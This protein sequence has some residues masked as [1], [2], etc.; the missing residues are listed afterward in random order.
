MSSRTELNDF[1]DETSSEP[2]PGELTASRRAIVRGYGPP[3]SHTKALPR[4]LI[5][6]VFAVLRTQQPG[7][8]TLRTITECVRYFSI[9]FAYGACVEV[10]AASLTGRHCKS[11]LEGSALAAY[12]SVDECAHSIVAGASVGGTSGKPL[13]IR[14]QSLLMLHRPGRLGSP[15][16]LAYRR[17]NSSTSA[18]TLIMPRSWLNGSSSKETG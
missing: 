18:G 4:L 13:T 6:P 15:R 3:A 7:P 12:V 2:R 5:V 8:V 14:T 9:A 17:I 16:N 11:P 10:A 1:L